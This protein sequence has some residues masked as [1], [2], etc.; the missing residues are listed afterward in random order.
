MTLG[1]RAV[2]KRNIAVEVVRKEGRKA[3][4]R[5]EEEEAEE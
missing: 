4:T 3:G 2:R 1:R 5:E